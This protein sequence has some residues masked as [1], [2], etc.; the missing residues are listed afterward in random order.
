MVKRKHINI[1]TRYEIVTKFKMGTSASDLVKI[2]GISRKTVYNLVEKMN[3]FGNVEDEKK[4]GQKPVLGQREKTR[5][6]RVLL[7]NP[8]ISTNSHYRKFG[9]IN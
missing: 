8:T 1:A 7:L 9:K 5:L 6:M 4:S 2:Y 3:T